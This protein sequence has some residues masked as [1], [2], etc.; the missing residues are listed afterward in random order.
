MR[1]FLIGAVLI[2]LPA[3]AAAFYAAFTG[4]YLML[5]AAGVV[6]VMNTLPFVA[7]AFLLRKHKDSADLGH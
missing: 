1:L 4:R 3:I 2:T 5:A 6:L 7:A